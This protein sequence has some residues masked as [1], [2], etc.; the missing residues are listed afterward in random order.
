MLNKGDVVVFKAYAVEMPVEEQVAK[1]GDKMTILKLSSEANGGTPNEYHAQMEDGTVTAVYEDE[2][3]LET[4]EVQT[5]SEVSIAPA[6][7]VV[8]PTTAE[9]PAAKE[10]VQEVVEQATTEKPAKPAKK[11]AKTKA[12]AKVAE[13]V[14]EPVPTEEVEEEVVEP[15]VV[16]TD[17]EMQP[18]LGVVQRNFGEVVQQGTFM[19]ETGLIEHVHRLIAERGGLAAAQTIKQTIK[20]QMVANYYLMGGV[21]SHIYQTKQYGQLGYETDDKDKGFTAYVKEH[22]DIEYRRAMYLKD[23]YDRFTPMGEEFVSRL[24]NIGWSLAKEIAQVSKLE[25][26]GDEDVLGLLEYAES[27]TRVE[28]QDKIKTEYVNAGQ[29]G[30]QEERT[31]KL[32][33]SFAFFADQGNVVQQ[34][35]ADART[36]HGLETDNE[37]LFYII[38]EWASAVNGN[39]GF[40]EE[41][42]IASV[43]SRFNIK[44]AKK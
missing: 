13:P 7:E 18:V 43:E 32:S 21:L 30:Q 14:A 40:T 6:P 25:N 36:T 22:L 41:M 1:A 37:A 9:E 44:L 27:H 15:L 31:K 34:A 39:A 16:T 11:A 4:T 26:V 8:E 10:V 24:V 28:L 2:V 42:A 23:I 20:K 3:V 33:M 35:I 5:A 12:K 19:P 17:G 38:Q 29:G